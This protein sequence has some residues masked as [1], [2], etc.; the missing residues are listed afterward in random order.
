MWE[1]KYGPIGDPTEFDKSLEKMQR[2]MLNSLALPPDLIIGT[3]GS[4]YIP[5]PIVTEGSRPPRQEYAKARKN[6]GDGRLKPVTLHAIDVELTHAKG[7]TVVSVLD[8]PT[9]I[10][11][12]TII[13]LAAPGLVP[14]IKLRPGSKEEFVD[15]VQ[16][17]TD[18]GARTPRQ[19]AEPEVMMWW[20]PTSASYVKP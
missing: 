20:D 19:L 12:K 18:I 1:A 9:A 7:A 11:G 2:Q 4:S 15:M 3:E 5:S 13:I 8:R 14:I 10:K 6:D 17:L 16:S